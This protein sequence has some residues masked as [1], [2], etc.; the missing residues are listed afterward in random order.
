M[1]PLPVSVGRPPS[2][3]QGLRQSRKGAKIGRF[4]SVNT[5]RIDNFTKRNGSFAFYLFLID[6]L[7]IHFF[8]FCTAYSKGN[9]NSTLRIKTINYR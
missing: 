3:S 8:Y 1:K 4:L 2:V 6:S 7:Q 9:A 5:I